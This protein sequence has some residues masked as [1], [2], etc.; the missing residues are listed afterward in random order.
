MNII[1]MCTYENI[2]LSDAILLL[3]S[4]VLFNFSVA[5]LFS[6][7][8]LASRRKFMFFENLFMFNKIC[9]CAFWQLFDNFLTLNSAL[10]ISDF[11]IHIQVLTMLLP[12][13]SLWCCQILFAN[14]MKPNMFWLFKTLSY[15]Q[16]PKLALHKG[17]KVGLR[18]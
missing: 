14:L 9:Q 3:Q 17:G 11:S 1:L 10:C 7:Y 5:Q 6:V 12:H 2:L 13:S 15:F 8:G 4:H 18:E 16:S